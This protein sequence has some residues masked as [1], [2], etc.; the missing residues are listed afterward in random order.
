MYGPSRTLAKVKGQYHMQAKHRGIPTRRTS[1]NSKK[2]VGLIGCGNFAH[3]NIAYY[4]RRNRGQVI[5]GVM[6]LNLDRAISMFRDYQA[7][8][9]TLDAAEVINDPEIDL[10]YI[11]SN[12]AS[13]AEYAIAAIGAGKAVHIEK[14]HVIDDDQLHRLGR[15]VEMAANPRIRVGFNR[16]FSPIGIEIAQAVRA[17]SGA[18]MVNWFI[19]GHEIDPGH[20]Y[21]RPEEGGRVL[22]NLCHWS[23][24]TLRLIP[25]Q[26]RYPIR[27]LP[28]RAGQSDCDLSVS[29][30]FGDGSIGVL[31]FSAK[32][33]T[34]EGVREALNVHKGDALIAMK[35]FWTL[36]IDENEKKRGKKSIFKEH[37]HETAIMQ[38]YLMSSAGGGAAGMDFGYIRQ[39]AQLFIATRTALESNEEVVL[40]SDGVIA[41]PSDG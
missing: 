22:G 21:F 2:H 1:T 9:A 33:H 7:D 30:V 32:G 10:V 16:P 24:F 36:T 12:H 28:G 34:F 40:G 4:L 17:Q 37:G 8:Y 20:W 3:S 26:D 39:T 38:S 19:A 5:R 23:D 41:E 18:C 11:A 13:H 35:D 25:S 31:S 14:P 27:I 29:Y 6:D 15:A